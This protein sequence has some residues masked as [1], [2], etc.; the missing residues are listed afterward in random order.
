MKDFDKAL[1]LTWVK[2]LCSTPDAPW[3]YIPKSFLSSVCGT[4]LF[5]C[6]Y[7]FNLLDLN[8]Q[9]LEF[10]K[11][12]IHHWQKIVSTTPHSKTDILAQTIWNNKFITIDQK[13]VLYICLSGT[14]QE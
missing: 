12:I 10:Y 14:E 2:R 6:N 1:K 7:D 3:K 9:L 8:S 11:Q 5:Q 4:D 13:M